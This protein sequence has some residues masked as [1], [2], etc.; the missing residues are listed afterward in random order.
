VSQRGVGLRVRLLAVVF[1]A[2]LPAL[3]LIL[4]DAHET[5]RIAI[6]QATESSFQLLK[7]ASN[8]QNDLN[9]QARTLN[10]FL[11]RDPAVLASDHQGCSKRLTEL[12]FNA[13][14]DSDNFYNFVA[15]DLNG[16]IYCAARPPGT[17]N[18]HIRDRAYFWQVKDRRE[19]VTG[20]YIFGKIIKA[21]IIPVAGPIIADGQLKG[22]MLVTINLSW[23]ART[24]APRLPP[25]AE[26][27]LYDSAGIILVRVPNHEQAVGTSDTIFSSFLNGAEQGALR[28]RDE[29][30]QERLYAFSRLNYGE[31]ALYISVSRPTR[32]LFAEA[33][34]AMRRGLVALGVV[35]LVVLLS[36]WG[37]GNSLI[38]KA[39]TTLTEAARLMASGNLSTRVELDRTDE[40]GQLGEAFNEM[41]S[42]LERSTGEAEQREAALH[43]ANE[44]KSSFM[45]I[46]SHEIR[47]PMS[48]ILGMARLVLDTPLDE[49]QHD[50]MESLR[51]SAEALLSIINDILDFSKLEAGQIE[52][53]HQPFRP[54]HICANVISLLRFRADE[55]N[56]QLESRI[57]PALPRWLSGDSG[58]LRQ[59]LLNLVGNA[60]KFT[61]KGSVTLVVK[62]ME[63]DQDG[64][65]VEFS[66]ID[67]GIGIDGE[68]Q[69]RL[70]ESFV[71]ADASISRRFGGTGLGLAICKRLVEG[72]GGAIGVES[73]MGQGSRFWFR[74]RYN[75]AEAPDVPAPKPLPALPPLR[76]LLAE[77][78][79]VNQKVA[80][81]MLS[82]GSH[83]VTLANNGRE[84]LDLA[85]RQDFDLILMDMQMPE[86]DGLQ[87]ARAIRTLPAPRGLLP[88]IALTAN[89]M[90]S[91]VERC[92]DAGMNAHLAKPIDPDI[93]IHTIADVLDADVLNTAP[94]EPGDGNQDIG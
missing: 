60:T 30:N 80:L 9:N 64:V 17:G 46:M 69:A 78:N 63:E 48:G 3:A 73:Q 34:A 16:D 54:S 66:V 83:Q 92:L 62:P 56:L 23:I 36:A 68:A 71:Q 38:I 32:V 91:D 33:D 1:A 93:M 24:M 84:A 76:V 53:E 55:Q 19:L 58:R 22:V 89:A 4:Y 61:P 86:M 88:I 94:R 90:G 7:V 44:A 77:D 37:I 35:T 8:Y 52:Y 15:S 29:E 65:L 5:R 18:N 11:A 10:N 51:I 79:P 2:V 26:L 72:Q 45:A 67:T 74:L 41:A 82:K 31:H 57:D 43:R 85:S 50:R 70:F 12:L 20:E 75:R 47:T 42:A 40:I 39:V 49:Q 87:A 28:I 6:E 27:R 21:P 81:G 14:N 13:V 25:D 59:I